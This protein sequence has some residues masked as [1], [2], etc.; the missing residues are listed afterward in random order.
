[1]AIDEANLT[2][3]QLVKLNALRKSIGEDL[4][5]DVFTKWLKRQDNPNKAEKIDPVAE[6]LKAALAHLE[7]DESFRLG[8]QGYTVRRARGKGASGF[9]VAKNGKQ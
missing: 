9:V 7:S 1:M 8:N 3:G 5:E 2:K 6:R 4:A